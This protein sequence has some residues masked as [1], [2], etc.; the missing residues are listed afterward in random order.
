VSLAGSSFGTLG[1]RSSDGQSG[2]ASAARWQAGPVGEVDLPAGVGKTALGVALVRVQESR[3][4]DRL[5]LSILT[6]RLSWRRRQV[7]LDRPDSPRV[8]RALELLADE[9]NIT[10]ARLPGDRRPLTYQVTQHKF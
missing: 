5:F 7:T 6:P 9:L 10:P 3:R 2:V 1:L 8:A 4:P